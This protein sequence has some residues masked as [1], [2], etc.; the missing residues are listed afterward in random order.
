MTWIGW[1]SIPPEAFSES[2]QALYTST[3]GTMSGPKGPPQL[4]ISPTL[5]GV[6]LALA[7]WPL[8][9][10]DGLPEEVDELLEADGR[11]L[12]EHAPRATIA[13]SAQIPIKPFRGGERTT[14]FM[15][16]PPGYV[17]DISRNL[18]PVSHTVKNVS[19]WVEGLSWT[20]MSWFAEAALP[21]EGIG[22]NAPIREDRRRQGATTLTD[23]S[24]N[25]AT[26]PVAK[27]SP[28]RQAYDGRQEEE[29]WA[30]AGLCDHGGHCG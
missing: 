30:N 4:Q 15:P 3:A 13:A 7:D 11:L 26:L 10:V 27:E 20:K 5:I 17:N 14:A 24:P 19:I 28:R 29:R 2:A 25:S 9:E 12:E 6:P 18:L 23:G 22:W 16:S 8:G 1:P 21:G